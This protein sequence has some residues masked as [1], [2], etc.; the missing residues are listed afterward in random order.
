MAFNSQS[1]FIEITKG[2]FFL[3]ILKTFLFVAGA[4][5]IYGSPA[6]HHADFINVTQLLP[7]SGFILDLQVLKEATNVYSGGQ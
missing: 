2:I 7:C 4:V 5:V 6:K 1:L 3:G